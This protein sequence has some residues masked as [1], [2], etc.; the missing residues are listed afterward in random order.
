MELSFLG[1]KVPWYESSIIREKWPKNFVDLHSQLHH[2]L[3]VD[4]A[5]DYVSLCMCPCLCLSLCLSV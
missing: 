2:L 5:S 1:T 3:S 4:G